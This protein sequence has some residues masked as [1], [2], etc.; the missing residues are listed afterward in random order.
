M[1]TVVGVMPAGFRFPQ[2][3][4]LWVPAI[5]GSNSRTKRERHYLGVIARLKPGLTVAHAQAEFDALARRMELQ[6]PEANAGLG[7]RLVPLQTQLAGNF[8]PALLVLFGA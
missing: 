6:Y 8:R 3:V 1:W 4:D 7:I 2:N 5:F